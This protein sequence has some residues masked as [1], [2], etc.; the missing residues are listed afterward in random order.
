MPIA[1]KGEVTG[2]DP[3]EFI[4]GHS[5]RFK[6]RHSELQCRLIDNYYQD[7]ICKSQGRIQD[8]VQGAGG[9]SK[10]SCTRA[11]DARNFQ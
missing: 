3:E 11:V 1:D 10:Q 2:D 7:T 6:V 8:F 5:E 9:G 4:Q